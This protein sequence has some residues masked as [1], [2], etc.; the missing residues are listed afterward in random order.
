MQVSGITHLALVVLQS[1]A[2]TLVHSVH[3]EFQHPGASRTYDA[4]AMRVYWRDM[5]TMV[6]KYVCGCNVCQLRSLK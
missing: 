6:R 1:L 5:W 4:L 2:L 3:L